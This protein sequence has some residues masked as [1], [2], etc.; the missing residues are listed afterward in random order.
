MSLPTLDSCLRC[1]GN[2]DFFGLELLMEGRL[3]L[4]LDVFDPSAEGLNTSP[5]MFWGPGSLDDEAEVRLVT[6]TTG[7]EGGGL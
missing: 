2:P 4:K 5:S 1:D 6:P 3:K 7:A